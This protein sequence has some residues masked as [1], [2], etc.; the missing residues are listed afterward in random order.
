MHDG[1]ADGCAVF[2]MLR[3]VM[4]RRARKRYCGKQKLEHSGLDGAP[5]TEIRH[6]IVDP[7]DG[8]NNAS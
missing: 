3:W 8:R 5:I 4:A 2:E 1:S 6:T 7:K